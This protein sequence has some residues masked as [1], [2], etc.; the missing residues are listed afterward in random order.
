MK[1]ILQEKNYFMVDNFEKLRKKLWL[2][3]IQTFLLKIDLAVFFVFFFVVIEY[4]CCAGDVAGNVA[5]LLGF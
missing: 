2:K 1:T 4:I 3:T 5:G